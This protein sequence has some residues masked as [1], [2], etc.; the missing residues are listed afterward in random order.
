M[1]M[2]HQE[3][4]RIGDQLYDRY[5]RCLEAE[6]WGEFVAIATDGRTFLAPTLHEVTFEGPKNLGHGLY[7]FRIGERAV[8]KL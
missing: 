4:R 8:G 1:T 3:R 2:T 5:A 7:I 6:H